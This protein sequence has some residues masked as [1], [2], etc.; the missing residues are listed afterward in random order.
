[1]LWTNVFFLIVYPIVL[2]LNYKKLYKIAKLFLTVTGCLHITVISVY[3]GSITG[4]ELYFFL[5][6][7]ITILIFSQNEIPCLILICLFFLIDYI[8]TQ[9][10]YNVVSPTYIPESFAKKLYYLTIVALF[11][12]FCGIVLFFRCSRLRLEEE[13][14]KK[15]K[16]MER[17][18]FKLAKY[19]SPQ[20]YKSIF[21]GE[22]EVIIKTHRRRLTVFFSDIV[23]FT[24]KAENT[25]IQE[26]TTWLNTYLADMTSI[27][28]RYGGTLDKFVGDSLMIFFGDPQSSGEKQDAV[29]CILM[30]LEMKEH[31]KLLGVNIRIGINTGDCIV[32]NFGSD[33]HMEYTIIGSAVNL[34]A[35]LE[36]QSEP[37]K[38]LISDMTYELV[39]DVIRCEERGEIRVKGIDRNIHTYWAVGHQKDFNL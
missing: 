34:A 10:L 21:S 30:A 11:F 15:K 8:A 5:A 17:L 29:K 31:A 20:V 26:L 4:F 18:A 6:L 24:T 37:G 9:F 38:I 25:N 32:G 23:E 2:L 13:L 3:F 28:L 16:Q 1:M 19:L 35:R 39:K 12:A 27:A 7:I 36:A 14:E 33:K 22:I